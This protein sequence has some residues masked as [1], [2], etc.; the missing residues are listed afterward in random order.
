MRAIPTDGR[1]WATALACL[2]VLAAAGCA[3]SAPR[4]GTATLVLAGRP[5]VALLPLENLSG[6]A[7]AAEVFG[8]VLFTELVRTGCCE[9]IEPGEV[10]A[11]LDSLG[12]RYTGALT[13]A[14]TRGLARRLDARYVMLGTVLE[15][16]TVRTPEGD[17]PSAAVTLRLLEPDSAR[18]VWADAGYR[19]GQ[20]KESVFGYGRERSAG[21]LQA[22]LAA[23]LLRP[24][25]PDSTKKRGR[26]QP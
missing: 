5:R 10:E 15:T 17:V 13:A 7:D 18:V 24:F 6:D 1:R 14:D 23:E 25:R 11:A 8:R 19:T 12:V 4:H 26:R 16:G 3:A 20:D 9:T 21:R 2:V 22:A